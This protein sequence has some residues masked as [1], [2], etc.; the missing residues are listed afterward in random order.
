VLS[1]PGGSSASTD[2]VKLLHDA[3]WLYADA[4]GQSWK[5]KIDLAPAPSGGG[6]AA[7]SL[8]RIDLTAADADALAA[9]LVAAAEQSR[10][11]GGLRVG[12]RSLID[13]SDVAGW[14]H[15]RPSTIR[16]WLS[17]GGPKGNPFPPPDRRYRGRSY[18]RRATIEAWRTRQEQ[19]RR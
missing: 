5:I 8:I 15:V 7:P 10:G 4:A 11:G 18:W 9:V 19:P 12:A 14:L 1:R 3:F 17:R 16:G 2:R 13:T 6:A